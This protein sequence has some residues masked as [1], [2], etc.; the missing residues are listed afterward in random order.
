MGINIGIL[1]LSFQ[2][3][4]INI[5]VFE[6]YFFFSIFSDV[7]YMETKLENKKAKE[8]RPLYMLESAKRFR[9]V[10]NGSPPNDISHMFQVLFGIRDDSCMVTMKDLLI[11]PNI[12]ILRIS[13]IRNQ[14]EY[15]QA[16]LFDELNVFGVCRNFQDGIRIVQKWYD[17]IRPI[18]DRANDLNEIGELFNVDGGSWPILN[19]EKL[20]VFALFVDFLGKFNCAHK[21][22]LQREDVK[23]FRVRHTNH[24]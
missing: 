6:D 17:S 3:K 1:G 20:L 22:L 18:V 2:I 8:Q 5:G 24:R 10:I 7:E 19:P 12:D 14:I 4:S 23:R 16:I 15:E 21:V 13:H 11:Q 9:D